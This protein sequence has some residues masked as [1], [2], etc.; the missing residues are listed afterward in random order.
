MNDLVSII[1]AVVVLGIALAIYFIPTFVAS[2]HPH[3]AGIFLLNLFFGWTLIGWVGALIWAV[4]KPEHATAPAVPMRKCPYCA[5]NIRLEATKCRYCQS[6]VPL[7]E[8]PV[9]AP[10]PILRAPREHFI[11]NLTP[12]D[13]DH[14]EQLL[15]TLI[16]R[17]YTL[18]AKQAELWEIRAPTGG[19]HYVYSL[20]QLQRL[21][22]TATQP[23]E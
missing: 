10:Q 15:T 11:R 1:I 4:T 20:E 16:A 13:Y 8:A 7:P 22:D 6:D 9:S 5:E 3:M 2:D 14:T 17:G 18:H 19:L 21:A 23:R 12:T